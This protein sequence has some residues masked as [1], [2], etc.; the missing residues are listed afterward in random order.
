MLVVKNKLKHFSP[1]GTKRYFPVNSSRKNSI[2][3]TP[4][5]AALSRG[6]KPRIRV[7]RKPS[8]IGYYFGCGYC[9]LSFQYFLL[10]HLTF[11]SSSDHAGTAQRDVTRENSEGLGSGWEHGLLLPLFLL[12]FFSRSLT[13]RRIPLFERLKLGVRQFLIAHIRSSSHTQISCRQEI[14]VWV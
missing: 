1:L 8:L 10:R 5:M 11:S 7:L 14:R 9:L 3:L 4:N 2:V 12:I 6:C 13:S